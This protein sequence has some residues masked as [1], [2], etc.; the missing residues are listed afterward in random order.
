LTSEVIPI[1]VYDALYF[2]IFNPNNEFEKC[3]A[4]EVVNHDAIP[5]EMESFI[6]VHRLYAVYD[7]KISSAD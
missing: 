7:Y 2:T 3:V 6:L 5:D 4:I 1:Q